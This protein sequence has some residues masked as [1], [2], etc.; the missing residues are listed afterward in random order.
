MYISAT[1]TA[2][3]LTLRAPLFRSPGVQREIDQ[4]EG[5]PKGDPQSPT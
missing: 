3:A 2:I 1:L 5:R 4:G